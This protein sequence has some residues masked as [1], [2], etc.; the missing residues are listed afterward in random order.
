MTTA[1]IIVLLVVLAPVIYGASTKLVESLSKERETIDA[2]LT[3]LKRERAA[4]PEDDPQRAI[5]GYYIAELEFAK[6]KKLEKEI[7]EL[8]GR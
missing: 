5:L 3:R 4:L 7:K 1:L 8:T 6:N 2:K